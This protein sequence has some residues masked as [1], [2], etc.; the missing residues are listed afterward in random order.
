MATRI[1]LRRDTAA[2]WTTSNPILAQG[3]TGFETDTRMVKLGDG[4]THWVDLKYAVTGNLK[5]TN[6]TIHGDDVVSISSGLGDRS[7]WILT[8][9]ANTGN[10]DITP[11]STSAYT[12]AV[13]YDSAGNTFMTGVY[14]SP[15][16][17]GSGMFLVKTDANGEV[18]FSKYYNQLEAF[19]YSMIV[20]S[21]DDVIFALAEYDPGSADTVLVKVSGANGSFIWQKYLADTDPSSNDVALCVD[22]DPSNNVIIA[23]TTA[24]GGATEFWVAKFRGDTGAEIWQRQYDSDGCTDTATGIAVDSDGNI[25]VV[26]ISNGPGSFV[27]VFKLNGANGNVLWQKRIINL[28]VQAN[29]EYTGQSWSNDDV[30]SSDICVDSNNNFYFSLTGL[31]D[32]GEGGGTVAGIQ[33]VSGAGQLLWSKAV[34]YVFFFSGSSSLICDADNNLYLTSTLFDYRP[35]N[36]SNSAPQFATV[37]TK[38]NSTGR[39]LWGKTLMREQASAYAGGGAGWSGELIGV[40][41]TVSVNANYILVGG[42]FYATNDYDPGSQD[43]NNNPFLAQLD[44]AGT[45]FVKDGWIYKDNTFRIFN[46]TAATADDAVEEYIRDLTNSAADIVVTTADV[47]FENNTDTYNLA[48]LNV[49]RVKTM[50][51]DGARLHLPENGGLTL[52]RKHIGHY[53]SIG[54]FDLD[55]NEGNNTGGATWINSVTGDAAGNVYA[56][57]GWRCTNDQ[58]ND[59]DSD[60][61]VPLVYKIDSEGA[62]VWSAGNNLN[63]WDGDMIS[64]VY[65]ESDN[66]VIVMGH[67]YEADGHEGFN[68]ITLDSE[69]GQMKDILHV[70][71]TGNTP[72]GDSEDLYPTQIALLSDGTPVVVGEIDTTWIEYANVT[73]GG[74]GL[75]G[76][77]VDGVLVI[78]KSVFVKEGVDLEYP[79]ISGDWYIGNSAITHVNSYEGTASVNT[80]AAGSGA[81]FD[82]ETTNGSPPTITAAVAAGFAGTGYKAGNY[83]RVLGSAIVGTD[84]TNDVIIKVLTIGSG[85]SI[86]T[87]EVYSWSSSGY[88]EWFAY[89][90]VV[91]T[92][93]VGTG[94]TFDV[95]ANP[96]TR[97]YTVARSNAGTNYAVGDTLKVLGSLLGGTDTTN[98]AVITVATVTG[99][100]T[101]D[102][103]TRTG[104]GQ[105]TTIKL[106]ITSGDFTQAGTYTVWHNT[107][108]DAFIWTPNWNL[109]FGGETGND[110]IKAMAI[111]SDDNII[112]GGHSDNLDLG[113]A[114]TDWGQDG[115]TAY[116][117]KFDKDGQKLW[118]K[119]VDGHEGDSVVWGTAVDSSDDIYAVFKSYR[120]P[121]VIKL[122]SAGEFVW[123]V[124]LETYW[125][126]GGTYSIAIDSD[127][128]IVVAGQAESDDTDNSRVGNQDNIILAKFDK[129]GNP[130]WKRLL[131]S[132]N[133]MYTSY[134]SNYGNNLTVVGD[135][136]IWGGVA[137]RWNDDDDDI[138]LVAQLPVDGTGVGSNGNYTYDIIEFNLNRYTT[139]DTFGGDV[140][141]VRDVAARLGTRAHT[142][143]S[144]RYGAGQSS[145][146]DS[147]SYFSGATGPL[148]LYANLDG[149]VAHV[150]EEG[151]GDITGVKEIVF[152]DGT[153]QSTSSQDI[154]QV[155]VSITNRGDDDYWLRYEDRGKHI[156][157]DDA[158]GVDIVIPDY[159][160]VPFPVGTTIVIVTDDD[161]QTV[162]SDDNNDYMINAGADGDGSYAWIIPRYSMVT[163]LKIRQGYN[164]DGTPDN[165]GTWMIAGPGLTTPP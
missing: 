91:G 83:I 2:N 81:K 153:R 72:G 9:N 87:V 56:S 63:Q 4:A 124:E 99:Q 23:G 92:T 28:N 111:D 155:D 74:A 139:N 31:Y 80:T 13:A 159:E 82:I 105:N 112:V 17:G 100:G 121:H 127:D 161:S 131:W 12:T 78:N 86:A 143:V 5:V 58:W 149:K 15:S 134:N 69:S 26:G 116:V 157:M 110:Q 68:V 146:G 8:V 42:G 95:I 88:G 47:S 27:G 7:N 41:Q 98:D 73:S 158:Q 119:A 165:S 70:L 104:I 38:F 52:S 136:M 138:A 35:Q 53:T 147:S 101:I 109:A 97:A 117:A 19:G 130:L 14:G 123:M 115:Q 145:G 36:Q 30:L 62:I 50:T 106:E 34:S 21:N 135:K 1:K 114:T 43:W 156:F 102:T 6:N 120:N 49:S 76:S 89:T 140:L 103:V 51:L 90:E 67:D 144:E 46:M 163:L 108:S 94:A 37:V 24:T 39:K 11:E 113:S 71:G 107:A 75:A 20:D 48:Y 122:T 79:N 22:I 125:N 25:G 64:V 66:T 59:S 162:Y 16:G 85:G 45:D 40:G 154:P 55:G 142:L 96:A 33:K 148:T 44:K 54:K 18:L 65:R 3:E 57:G 84:G 141:I 129:D 152:E 10:T 133:G 32:G 151:G 128:N 150:L 93:L 61:E 118:A 77:T 132:N 164:S 60:V 160:D 126:V 29:E 137:N